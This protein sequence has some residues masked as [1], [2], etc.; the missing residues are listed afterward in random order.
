MKAQDESLSLYLHIPFCQ[1]RCSYCDFNTYTTVDELRH[2]YALAM[3][4]EIGV[5]SGSRRRQVHTIFFGGGTPSLMKASELELILSALRECFILSEDVEI[6]LEAN[7]ESVDRAFLNSLRKLGINRLSF[8]VQSI[9]PAELD[10]LGRTHSFNTVIQ[11]FSQSRE[12]GF[13]NINLD[14]IYGL[15]DQ[16]LS[17]WTDSLAAA[18]ELRPEHLSLYCL[19]IEA[20]TPLYRQLHNGL[21]ASPDPDV[22]ADQYE[23]ASEMTAAAGYSQYEISNWSLPGYR[24]EH[25]LTYWRNGQ[26]LGFGAGAHGHAAGW[27]YE[28]VKQPRVYIR[29]MTGQSENQYPWSQTVAD[30]H[31]LSHHEAMTDTIITQL[32]LTNEGL[33]LDAFTRTFGNSLAEAFPNITQ[34]LTELGLLERQGNRLLLTRHARL[35]SNQVFRRFI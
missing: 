34:E 33:D 1:Q 10:L 3:V 24:C 4:K 9:H 19:T 22:A 26:Y 8:G 6:T 28:V 18:I 29:R 25:N 30:Y 20:G 11:A 14:L 5:V 7:P 32:R 21:I 17:Q 12:A 23:L 35:L 31:R 16:T 15:P 13:D 27:R 2:T